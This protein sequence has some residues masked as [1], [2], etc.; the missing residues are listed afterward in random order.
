MLAVV[1]GGGSASQ[2]SPLARIL[3]EGS[4]HSV[5][6]TPLGKEPGILKDI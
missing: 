1:Q 6:L 4:H 2:S 3:Q 5:A